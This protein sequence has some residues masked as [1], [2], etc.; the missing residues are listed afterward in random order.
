MHRR[1][2]TSW[3]KLYAGI[4][5]LD[6]YRFDSEGGSCIYSIEIF[7]FYWNLDVLAG[8]LDHCNECVFGILSFRNLEEQEGYLE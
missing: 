7:C 8:G 1:W 3:R 6:V 5:D 2:R 4:Y